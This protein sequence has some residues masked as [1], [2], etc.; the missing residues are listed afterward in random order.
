[1]V[2]HKYVRLASFKF[3]SSVKFVSDKC[4]LAEDPA[5]DPKKKVADASRAESEEKR[6]DKPWEKQDHEYGKNQ[7]YP[8]LI[9]CQKNLFH[10]LGLF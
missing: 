10:S 7:E 8:N 9:K 6:Q 1:M 2:A 3:F 5:P 4:Q